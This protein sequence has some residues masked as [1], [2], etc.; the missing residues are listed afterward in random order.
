MKSRRY[1]KSVLIKMES[2][3]CATK[4]AMILRVTHTRWCMNKSCATGC[5][6]KAN[7]AG[8]LVK[9][10]DARAKG[11]CGT[12]GERTL[13]TWAIWQG[14]WFMRRIGWSSS[15]MEVQRSKGLYH[16]QESQAYLSLGHCVTTWMWVSV[17]IVICKKCQKIMEHGGPCIVCQVLD[18]PLWAW[19]IEF[20]WGCHFYC[21]EVSVLHVLVFI[22]LHIYSKHVDRT[23]QTSMF[24]MF[25]S[26]HVKG[27]Y[28]WLHPWIWHHPLSNLWQLLFEEA[29]R[30]YLVANSAVGVA[31]ANHSGLPDCPPK[32]CV[33]SCLLT[34]LTTCSAERSQDSMLFFISLVSTPKYL[35]SWL[36]LNAPNFHVLDVFVEACE[37]RIQMV[38]PIDLT[39]PFV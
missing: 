24:L 1:T 20:W 23:L 17:V 14:K 18:T 12:T 3:N 9:G 10:A 16:H 34:V 21:R 27:G 28:K 36:I 25:S 4:V 38:A 5:L 11:R 35:H 8:R 22:F 19:T 2:A 29:L 6:V 31:S 33:K 15:S 39:P 30:P 37:G 32:K 13:R 7:S 26:R